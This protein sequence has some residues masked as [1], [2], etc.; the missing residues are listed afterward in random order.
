MRRDLL[1]RQLAVQFPRRLVEA[2]ERAPR[3]LFVQPA[4]RPHAWIDAPL[5]IGFGQTISQPSTVLAMLEW[6]DV[7]EDSRILEVGAG[8]GWNAAMLGMLAP[9]GKVFT[10][11]IIPE[12]CAFARNNISSLQLRNVSVIQTDGSL[13]FQAEAPFDRIIV[14]AACPSRPDALL[15]QLEEGGILLAPVASGFAED[16][17]RYT[18]DNDRFLAEALGKYVFVPL[19]GAFGYS[20]GR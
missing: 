4:D 8:S 13:G 18:R 5:E 15:Q 17:M 9:R 14:T 20:S 1:V 2:F 19:R 12:L 3:D 11:E 10:L 7:R 16:M 6:L